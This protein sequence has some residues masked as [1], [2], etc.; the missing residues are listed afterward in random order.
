MVHVSRQIPISLG[1]D[2][3][4]NHGSEAGGR[5]QSATRTATERL[6]GMNAAGVLCFLFR[7]LGKG[8]SACVLVISSH[9][10]H[11]TKPIDEYLHVCC[12][13]CHFEVPMPMPIC[14]TFHQGVPAQQRLCLVADQI[15]GQKRHTWLP[16]QPL[17]TQTTLERES[18]LLCLTG[19]IS[20]QVTDKHYTRSSYALAYVVPT[21]VLAE[22]LQTRYYEVQTRYYHQLVNLQRP[23]STSSPSISLLTPD[24]KILPVRVSSSMTRRSDH[25]PAC[26][27]P[28]PVNRG[29][30]P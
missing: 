8:A 30:F 18:L 25:W 17:H 28:C 20:P 10:R 7:R 5:I 9:A 3:Q 1:D 27:S 21:L 16:L 6:P 19:S 24:M 15:R 12:A 22:H 23:K 11:T 29:V 13:P 26:A 14:L 2:A 4:S